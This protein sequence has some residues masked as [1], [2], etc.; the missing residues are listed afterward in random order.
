MKR[1]RMEWAYFL[2]EAFENSDEDPE[3]IGI[4]SA[5]EI[6]IVLESNGRYHKILSDTQECWIY[7][8]TGTLQD[9]EVKEP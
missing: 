2:Y 5:H 3:P 6:F 1:Y 8:A 4:L 7:I 9:R